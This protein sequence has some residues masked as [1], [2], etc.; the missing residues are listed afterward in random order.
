MLSRQNYFRNHQQQC[1]NCS[2]LQWWTKAKFLVC[3]SVTFVVTYIILVCCPNV[4]RSWPCNIIVLTIFVSIN[5]WL[6]SWHC[7]VVLVIGSCGKMLNVLT[8]CTYR[9]P[10]RDW[11]L[12]LNRAVITYFYASFVHVITWKSSGV[13]YQTWSKIFILI[14]GCWKTRLWNLFH[15]TELQWCLPAS[16]CCHKAMDK[17]CFKL[18]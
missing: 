17:V 6:S 10:N 18:V 11:K 5:P 3:C 12:I 14:Y 13:E 7:C 1:K 4:R 2:G 16:L 9:E 8:F 15:L